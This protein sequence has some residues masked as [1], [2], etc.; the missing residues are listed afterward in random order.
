VSGLALLADETTDR[1]RNGRRPAQKGRASSYSDLCRGSTCRDHS[2]TVHARPRAQCNL[3]V[4]AS[5]QLLHL[6]SSSESE[7]VPPDMADIAGKASG[8]SETLDSM[9]RM[10]QWSYGAVRC[11]SG[12]PKTPQ[13]DEEVML[14]LLGVHH[15]E[16]TR[17]FVPTVLEVIK[18]MSERP[19]TARLSTSE[20]RKV[21]ISMTE[22]RSY[23]LSQRKPLDGPW[24]VLLHELM[25]TEPRLASV[26][27][28][29]A[30]DWSIVVGPSIR[31]FEGI[32]DIDGYVERIERLTGFPQPA[33]TLA[34]PSPLDLVAAVDYL[35]AVWRV[36][37]GRKGMR[38]FTIPS[39]ERVAK[40]AL[41]ANTPE[42]FDARLS[43]LGE[44]LR[45]GNAPAKEMES[46]KALPRQTTENP[47][48]PLEEHLAGRVRSA[49][50]ARVRRAVTDLEH[51][52]ALR[53]AAQHAEAGDRAVRALNALG[54]GHPISDFASAWTTVSAKAVEALSAIREE[55]ATLPS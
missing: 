1:P 43:A 8:A 19:R 44:I 17:G 6:P 24:L 5:L 47:L 46:K 18:L 28:G 55:L 14:T 38:L 27:G 50:E 53:D 10:G 25:S 3:T 29:V 42:E 12:R 35:D 34:A 49:G 13:L 41:G 22:I 36:T 7:L 11:A 48:A 31:Q 39:A 21:L 40:L 20:P 33:P 26:T 30:A 52:L 23:F 45:S 15:C 9:P 4:Q 54:V 16:R 37:V 51:A 2:V 32:E